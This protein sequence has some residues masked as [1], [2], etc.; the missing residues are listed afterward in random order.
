MAAMD[1]EQGFRECE[2]YVQRHNIQQ[3][4]KDAIVNLC[5]SKPDNPITFLRD[6]FN[7]L[8]RVSKTKSN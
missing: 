3:I 7:K 4:L 8:E 2:A 1:D 6:Y 5:V